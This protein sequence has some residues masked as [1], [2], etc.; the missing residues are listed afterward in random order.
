[1]PR[2]E[3]WKLVDALG[4]EAQQGVTKHTT[5]LVTG[6]FDPRTFRPGATMSSKLE[7]A[8]ALAAKGQPIQVI[9]DAD[10]LHLVDITAD[11]VVQVKAEPYVPD[12][13]DSIFDKASARVSGLCN[14]T[15]TYVVLQP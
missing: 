11:E 6:D 4:G 15:Q 14:N 10:F 7:K 13:D 1:M 8:F 9:T 5:I 2:E 12:A 3:A